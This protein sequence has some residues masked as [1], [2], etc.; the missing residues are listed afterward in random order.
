MSYSNDNIVTSIEGKYNVQGIESI[1]Q[2]MWYLKCQNG[3]L[4]ILT[5]IDGEKTCVILNK[6]QV[7]VLLSELKDVFEVVFD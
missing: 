3:N 7:M 1:G 2:D 5:I 6:S 4:G